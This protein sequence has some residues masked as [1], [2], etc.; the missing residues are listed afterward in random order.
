[1]V[2]SDARLDEL[3]QNASLR[4]HPLVLRDSR[5]QATVSS[6]SQ[7]GSR[8]P[9]VVGGAAVPAPIPPSLPHGRHRP[10]CRGSSPPSFLRRPTIPLAPASWLAAPF[11]AAQLV[12][13]A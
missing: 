2:E 4:A 8:L 5:A 6:L 7:R 13:E 11:V 9:S 12:R 3:L 10:T 1:M